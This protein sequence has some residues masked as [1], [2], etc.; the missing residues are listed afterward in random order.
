MRKI[1]F[2]L[3]LSSYYSF[4][5]NIKK[6]EQYN[7]GKN[8]IEYIAKSKSGKTIIVST[9]NSRPTIKDEVAVNVFNYFR[10]KAPKDGDKITILANEAVVNGTCYI[11]VKDKLTSVEFHYE[12][13]E[14]NNGITEVYSNPEVHATS[15]IAD[16][17]E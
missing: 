8:G 3:L 12:T 4:G 7:Y 14:W 16:G 10:E 2:I 9:F 5:Q 11:K 13:V 6:V 1:I 15:V 17:D